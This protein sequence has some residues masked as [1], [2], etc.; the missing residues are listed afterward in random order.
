MLYT[1]WYVSYQSVCEMSQAAPLTREARK[2][3]TR[4]AIVAA[5]TKLFSGDGIEATSLDRIAKEIGLTKGAIYSTFSSKDEVVEAVATAN[6]VAVHEE[7]LFDPKV[8]I[9]KV[10]RLLAT[11]VMDVRKKFTRGQFVLFLELF[12]YE[13]RHGSWGRRVAAENRAANEADIPRLEKA[14]TERGEKLIVP[15]AEF[16]TALNSIAIGV[17]LQLERDPESLS[18]ESVVK[19]FESIAE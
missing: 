5:A 4:E 6:A 11:E 19:L 14:M 17:V 3:Q 13:R 18:T 7:H 1:A 10:L 2:E 16:F 9:K 8:P 12:L 15:A